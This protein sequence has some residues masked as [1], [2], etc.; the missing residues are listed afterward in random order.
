M[1]WIVFIGLMIS[2][3]WFLLR[4]LGVSLA[5]TRREI[6]FGGALAALLGDLLLLP[7]QAFWP[8]A[9]LPMQSLT[10]AYSTM[11]PAWFV[12]LGFE[13]IILGLVLAVLVSHRKGAWIQYAGLAASGAAIVALAL[14]THAAARSSFLIPALLVEIVH[15]ESVAFWLGGLALFAVLPK[16]I[17]A[18]CQ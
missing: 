4:L 6:I 5:A 13:V 8:G 2:G 9:G 12:R 11:P 14:T 10:N 17:R 3:G 16:A 7:V 18:D 15:V 1:R